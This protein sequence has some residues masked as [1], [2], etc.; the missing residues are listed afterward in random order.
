MENLRKEENFL[1]ILG[2]LYVKFE[3]FL[4]EIL[5]RS[6]LNFWEIFGKICTNFRMFGNGCCKNL[7]KKKNI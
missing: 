1:E 3:Q 6:S 5:S 4:G 7:K 2:K